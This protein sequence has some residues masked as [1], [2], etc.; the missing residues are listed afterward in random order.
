MAKKPC[1][2]C[3]TNRCKNCPVQ[4]E[5]LEEAATKAAN[6]ATALVN[7][8]EDEG[9]AIKHTKT[10]IGIPDRFIHL[11]EIDCYFRP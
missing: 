4:L 6:V 11:F 3:P 9:K 7:K 1:R 10:Y 8:G 2:S 5:K